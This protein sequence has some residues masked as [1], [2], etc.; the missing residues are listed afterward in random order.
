MRL[1]QSEGSGAGRVSGHDMQI[2][3]NQHRGFLFVWAALG[4]LAAC[5]LFLAVASGGYSLVAVRGL[6]LAVTSLVAERGLLGLVVTHKLS[7]PAACRI[8]PDQGLNSC[9]LQW[10]ADS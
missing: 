8:F 1:E 5:G 3:V 7:C 4:L 9:P 2:L 10:Q 6:P